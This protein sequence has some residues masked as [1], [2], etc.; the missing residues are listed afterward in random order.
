MRTKK[1]LKRGAV[2]KDT[3]SFIGGWVPDPLL[4]YVDQAIQ[5]QDS[6]RSKFIR[7]ALREKISRD[8][9]IQAA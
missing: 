5:I 4:E 6:D 7:A 8:L 3:S 2:Q 1:H 9:N